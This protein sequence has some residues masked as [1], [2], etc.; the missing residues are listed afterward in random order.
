ML[1]KKELKLRPIEKKHIVIPFLLLVS[2][3]L[4][5]P[6]VISI[7]VFTPLFIGT[8]VYVFL[9]GLHRENYVAIF[10]SIVYFIN[11]E[12]NLSLPLFFIFIMSLFVYVL[13]Y[14]LLNDMKKCTYC[15]AIITVILINV[16]YVSGLYLH[17]FIFDTQS[18][19]FDNMLWY[20]LLADIFVVILL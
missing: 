20:A 11:L 6:M 16:I 2:F 10:V 13:F 8:M 18:I 4:L 1:V 5:Y 12:V 17:D 19:V 7:Y 9:E 14:P 3:V 15:K